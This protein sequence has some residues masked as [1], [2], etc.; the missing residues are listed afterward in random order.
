MVVDS[1]K[2][3][4]PQTRKLSEIKQPLAAETTLPLPALGTNSQ[5]ITGKIP[6][7]E[8][9]DN[10]VQNRA[11]IPLNQLHDVRHSGKQNPA[12]AGVVQW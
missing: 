9:G 3:I 4:E 7:L 11:A 8:T 10:L 6:T 2:G 5:G 12:E 1:A